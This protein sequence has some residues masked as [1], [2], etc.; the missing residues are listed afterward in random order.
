VIDPSTTAFFTRPGDI[1]QEDITNNAVRVWRKMRCFRFSLIDNPGVNHF[2]LP[3]NKDVLARL[4]RHLERP[5]SHC[6]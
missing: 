1:N 4:V 3:G 6:R 2:E 5:R